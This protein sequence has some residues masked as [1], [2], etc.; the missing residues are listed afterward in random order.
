M[1]YLRFI[2]RQGEEA[3]RKMNYEF[4]GF[5]KYIITAHSTGSAQA[6]THSVLFHQTPHTV[7]EM[8]QD[9]DN[10]IF[11][12]L[13]SK[14]ISLKTNAALRRGLKRL[15]SES[16]PEL[17]AEP[18]KVNEPYLVNLEIGGS[19]KI[20]GRE[21][22]NLLLVPGRKIVQTSHMSS[23]ERGVASTCIFELEIPAPAQTLL[24]FTEL[25]CPSEQKR[26]QR[27]YWSKFWK[28]INGVQVESIDQTVYLKEKSAE[29][30]FNQL[31]DWKLLAKSI[32]NKIKVEPDGSVVFQNNKITARLLHQVPT[33]QVV[34]QWRHIEWPE[35]VFSNVTMDIAPFEGGCRVTCHIT[36]VPVDHYRDTE[37]TWR[38]NIWRKLGG[39]LCESIQQHVV[40]QSSLEEVREMWLSESR[41]HAA[42]KCKCSAGSDVG[43]AFA[44]QHL[45]GELIQV[46]SHQLVFRLSHKEWPH[47][48]SLA[49]FDFQE[50]S[51][52]TELILHHQ[53]VPSASVKAIADMWVLDFWNRMGGIQTT[54]IS[55]TTILNDVSSDVLYHALLDRTALTAITGEECTI[56]A[57]VGGAVSMHDKL[58][59]GRLT[60]LQKNSRISMSLRCFNWPAN[61]FSEVHYQLDEINAGKGTLLTINQQHIPIPHSEEILQRCESFCK[62]LKRHRFD[63]TL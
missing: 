10:D 27:E 62:S 31:T 6:I 19:F 17:A 2:T 29:T 58:V 5:F 38:T 30:I 56:I 36:V 7:Y 42:L 63:T 52:G 39:V 14:T 20:A 16:T 51:K 33:R 49:T 24:H 23:W 43:S 55:T 22:T 8:I 4:E 11:V 13:A 46:S 9:P 41:L 28:R 12:Y 50:T 15:G 45:K 26:T 40:F 48:P 44:A 57:Q 53:N 35:D 47:H 34:Q 32:K 1:G 21:G 3:W 60:A 18:S 54:A 37:K 59:K 61:H 25:N